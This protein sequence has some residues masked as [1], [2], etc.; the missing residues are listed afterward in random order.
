[1][2]RHKILIFSLLLT[3]W[4]I[5]ASKWV[6]PEKVWA[7]SEKV[8]GSS[9]EKVIGSSSEKVIRLSS[10]KVIGSSSEKAFGS[11]SKVLASSAKDSSKENNTGIE[12]PSTL[13]NKGNEAFAKSN[14]KN[15]ISLYKNICDLGYESSHLYY[16][17]ACAY[18]K[19]ND[20]ASSILYLE[21]AKKIDPWDEDIQYNLSFANLKTYDKIESQPEFFLLK[22]WLSL[23]L[24]PLGILTWLSIFLFSGGFLVLLVYLFHPIVLFKKVSFYSGILLIFL[25]IL[26]FSMAELQ[27][28]YL[29]NHEEAIV[30][31]QTLTVKSAPNEPSKA[32]FVIH[33]GTKVSIVE[34]TNDWSRI[35]LPNGNTGW[36]PSKDIVEI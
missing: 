7:S 27:T 36:V 32:L 24:I 29:K 18:F 4:F 25:G 1:M 12:S 22:S 30:F 20:M 14:Y 3:L 35:R 9:S 13:F 11:F 21:K 31:S 34:Q 15:A 10:K 26:S 33:D 19:D 8:F 6:C 16:N 28:F 23:L 5:I 2:N 17:L